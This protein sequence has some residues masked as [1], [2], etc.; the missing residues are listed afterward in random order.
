[1]ACKMLSKLLLRQLDEPDAS[2]GWNQNSSQAFPLH[3]VATHPPLAPKIRT[4]P[5][6]HA[7]RHVVA[8]LRWVIHRNQST[9]KPW[10]PEA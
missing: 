6:A 7:P 4:I 2:F 1:M 9:K 8:S 10:K 3:R 5:A